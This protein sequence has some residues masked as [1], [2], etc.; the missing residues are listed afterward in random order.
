MKCEAKSHHQLVA[1]R[2]I[3][4]KPNLLSNV[5]MFII[6]VGF[7][8]THYDKRC[9]EQLLQLSAWPVYSQERCSLRRTEV[10]NAP[11]VTKVLINRVLDSNYQCHWRPPVCARCWE[12]TEYACRVVREQLSVWLHRDCD[13]FSM[14]VF[15][16][17]GRVQRIEKVASRALFISKGNLINKANS[18]KAAYDLHFLSWLLN[19]TE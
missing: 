15:L 9:L 3:R 13:Y 12:V 14:R 8:P 6:Q 18:K 2:T 4:P 19:W 5:F 11:C 10:D 17:E 1:N 7:V 16:G